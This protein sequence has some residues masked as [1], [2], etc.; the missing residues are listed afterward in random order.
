VLT[1]AHRFPSLGWLIKAPVA[2]ASRS[3]GTTSSTRLSLPLRPS[4]PTPGGKLRTERQ[5]LAQPC[6]SPAAAEVECGPVGRFIQVRG[7]A[8][9]F[10]ETPPQGGRLSASPKS[11]TTVSGLRR[12]C[13]VFDDL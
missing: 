10:L 8:S 11:W 3:C 13:L 9:F 4:R 1:K 5:Q 12:S 2:Q 7:Y 6:P